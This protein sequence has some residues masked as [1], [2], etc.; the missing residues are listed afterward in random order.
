MTSR[1]ELVNSAM[2]PAFKLAKF[3]K[4]LVWD[5]ILELNQNKSQKWWR[6][7]VLNAE[8]AGLIRWN[9]RTKTWAL[10]AEGQRYIRS[11]N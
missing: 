2:I 6:S 10:T 11:V 8:S 1:E 3:A 7:A 4:P 9:S 5:Q